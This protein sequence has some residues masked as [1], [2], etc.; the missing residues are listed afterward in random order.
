MTARMLRSMDAEGYPL[1]GDMLSLVSDQLVPPEIVALAEERSRARAA[2]DWRSADELRGRIEAAGWRIEDHGLEFRLSPTRP[3]DIVEAGRTLYGSPDAVPS[4]SDEPD[5]PGATVVLIVQGA[6]SSV[7]TQLMAWHDHLPVGTRLLV[8]ADREAD[9]GD[10]HLASEIIWMAEPWPAG[11]ALR[12]A[13]RRVTS[14]IVVI[15]G[16][17]RVPVSDIVTPLVAALEDEVIAIVGSSGLVSADLWHPEPGGFGEVTV[18]TAD[19]YAFRRQDALERGEVDDRL[20][21]PGGV[22]AWLSLVLRDAGTSVPPRLALAI[23]LP[24]DPLPTV[25]EA[26][27]PPLARRDRYRIAERFKGRTDL[28][29]KGAMTS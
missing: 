22:A 25:P 24:L 6:D 23:E 8:A 9:P 17:R 18:V 16:G 5:V 19:C 2:R 29:R 26:E 4:R 7:A 27:Q 12:A 10:W 15:V 20:T 21:S 28:A 14:R 3:P 13:L 11:A 1:R